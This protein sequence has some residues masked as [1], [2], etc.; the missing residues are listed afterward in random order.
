ME[1]VDWAYVAGFIDADGSVGIERRKRASGEVGYSVKL[2]IT[3]AD[4]STMDWLVSNLEGGVYLT[5]RHSPKHH[6]T[7][8]R[9]VVRG[10]KAGPLLR[11]L[12]PYLRLK[13]KRAE[14][15][16]R[17]V[18]TITNGGRL[19]PESKRL[20]EYLANQLTRMNFRGRPR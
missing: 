8:W 16:L 6:Q 10:K 3:N 11:E 4:R 1:D 15:A 12:L 13:K 7:M 9:W 2:Y 20:R 18:E 17:F 14:L 19:D 5:N